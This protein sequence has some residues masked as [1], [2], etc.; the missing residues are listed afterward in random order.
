MV[1][2]GRCLA[3][4]A[5]IHLPVISR[6]AFE[7]YVRTHL[8]PALEPRTVV[9][10]DNLAPHRNLAAARALKSKGLLV[11]VFAAIQPGYEPH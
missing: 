8:A 3:V 6:L 11:P 9:I 7:T 1:F 2:K 4:N 10:L 5:Y